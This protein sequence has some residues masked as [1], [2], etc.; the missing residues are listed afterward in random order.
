M[1]L[2]SGWGEQHQLL[3]HQ[4]V[5]LPF[6]LMF[7]FLA[8]RGHL[9][10]T[11]RYLFL[12]FGG[13]VLAV[14]AMGVYSLLLFTSAIV[15]ALTVVRAD[16]R[17]IHS[18]VFC[19]QMTWQTFWHLLMQYRK[20]R[21]HEPADIRLFTAVSSLMLLTQRMTSF[22]MDLQEERVPSPPEASPQNRGRDLLLPLSSYVLNFTTL[23]GG[24]LFSYDRFI[25]LI[26][27]ISVSPP[28]N[29]L[30][31]VTLKV[32]QVSLLQWLR[33][34]VVYF[35]TR[36]AADPADFGVPVG[37]LW[38]WSLG[39]GFRLQYYSHWKISEC[40]NN[41][42]GLGFWAKSPADTPDWRMLSDGDLWTTEMSSRVSVF[43]R[44]WN[45]TTAA[46]LRRL[47]FQKFQT[48]PVLMTFGFSVWWH[49]LHL[50]Q[51]VGFFT[52]A[53]AVHADYRIH[54][55]VC[56]KL[57]STWRKTV[58]KCLSWINT[59][60]TITFVVIAVE[61]RDI[62]SLRLLFVTYLGPVFTTILLFILLSF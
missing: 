55:H 59:Q 8:K 45:A 28:P 40:L 13:C 11:N 3:M 27:G 37:T 26:K 19:I 10:L 38:I 53:A 58:Y 54:R 17:H 1:G 34:C 15:F 2:M 5:S 9:S 46:W 49:G 61:S 21:H 31:V 22:S 60:I 12:S 62:P 6:A 4:W 23:L 48:F 57:T 43:S 29:P 35:L 42:A 36:H 7:Y 47:V 25:S 44:R 14:A 16:P 30:G 51:F 56:P 20:H 33:Y 18:W 52:W 32:V 39:V 24:P 41:A 50:S